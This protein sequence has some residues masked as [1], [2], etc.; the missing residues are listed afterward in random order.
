L[1][2]VGSIVGIALLPFLVFSVSTH[3]SGRPNTAY[4]RPFWPY[5]WSQVNW[6]NYAAAI[7]A[8][9]WAYHGWM[10]GGS[11]VEEVQRPSRNIPLSLLGGVLLLIALYVSANVAYY[12]AI[13]REEMA[14]M[15]DSP[16][17]TQ[18]LLRLLG[19]LGAA[20]G[21]LI[22]MI[23]VLGSANG[24]ILVGPRLLMAM[25][26]DG[27]APKRLGRIH[28]KYRTPVMAIFAVAGWSCLLVLIVALLLKNCE[29]MF[30]SGKFDAQGLPEVKSPFDVLTDFAVFGSVTFETMVVA[31]LFVFRR[32]DRAP[33]LPY[34]CPGYPFVPALYVAFM[35]WILWNMLVN[36]EHRSETLIGFGFITA[37]VMV[38]YT[39]I[40]GKRIV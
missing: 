8:V 32:R 12:S 7:V 5:D 6:S 21:S 13:P 14:A 34:R 9:L 33:E 30:H 40:R 18:F 26:Q 24:N 22:I 19:P 25:G 31:S 29:W 3:I 10:N 37:G 20:L 36:P 38:Y 39:A 28:R 23:S 27:L 11:A 4:M 16:V 1:L 17:A 15:K 35:A 2:K